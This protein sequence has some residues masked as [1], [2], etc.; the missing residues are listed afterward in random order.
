MNG[1]EIRRVNGCT[2]SPR[3]ETY[4][5]GRRQVGKVGAVALPGKLGAVKR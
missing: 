3:N 2:F 5:G 1:T 4:A